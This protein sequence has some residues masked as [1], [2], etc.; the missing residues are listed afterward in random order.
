MDQ[1]HVERLRVIYVVRIED[2]TDMVPLEESPVLRERG[3]LENKV[4]GDDGKPIKAVSTVLLYP[5][6]FR[7]YQPH[8]VAWQYADRHQGGMG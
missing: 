3:L 8:Q 6:R 7:A 5:E 4:L 2:D 1:R